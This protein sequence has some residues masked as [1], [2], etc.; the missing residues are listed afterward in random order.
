MK[1]EITMGRVVPLL[2]Q[3]KRAAE[4]L[5]ISVPQFWRLEQRGEIP[6]G[7]K[8]PGFTRGTHWHRDVLA[9]LADKW[10]K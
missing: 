9:S 10:A 4:F 8:I 3:R 7:A 1:P 5:G 6:P 2:M